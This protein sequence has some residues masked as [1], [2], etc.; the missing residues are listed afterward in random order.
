M[1]K[2]I[3]LGVFCLIGF[4]AHAEPEI[5][6]NQIAFKTFIN[7]YCKTASQRFSFAMRGNNFP[8]TNAI[9]ESFIGK[10]KIPSSF[11]NMKA[12]T[13]DLGEI[14]KACDSDAFV[15]NVRGKDSTWM[16]ET[17]STVIKFADHE[18]ATAVKVAKT[19]KDSIKCGAQKAE[20]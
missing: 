20:Q 19:V 15:R 17:C 12:L 13:D 18:Y 7:E 3:F 5:D 4:S 2:I 6:Y 9:L 10:C 1:K 16:K 14:K 11:K 8:E